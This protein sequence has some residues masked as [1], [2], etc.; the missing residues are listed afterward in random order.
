M[1]AGLA[2]PDWPLCYGSLLPGR[3][4]NLQVFLE[5]FHRLDAFLVGIALLVQFLASFFWRLQ[6]PRWY[7]WLAAGLVILVALQGLLGG[8][9]VLELLPSGVVT[10]HLALALI[11]LSLTSGLSQLLIAADKEPAPFWWKF[12]GSG[13]L[14]LLIS[15]CLLGGRMATTWSAHRCLSDGNACELVYYHRSLAVFS[16][17]VVLAFVVTAL[18]VGGWARSQWPFLLAVLGLLILQLSLG[19]LTLSVGLSKPLLT[20]GHQ[21]VASLLVAL[22]AAL[23]CRRPGLSPSSLSVMQKENSLK[24]CHG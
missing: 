3:Q 1:E 6:L 18:L 20:I 24:P 7:P 10:A 11:L 8:L 4:M 14:L 21:L 13:S 12:M 15:Q 17:C 23:I 19:M 9:T 16:S 2:C 22:L 5:W